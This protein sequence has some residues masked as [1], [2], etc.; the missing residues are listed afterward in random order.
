MTQINTK[1]VEFDNTTNEIGSLLMNAIPRIGED[2]KILG[3][4]ERVG[5]DVAIVR[6]V[7]WA[8]AKGEDKYLVF[9]GCI[10][11][12]QFRAPWDVLRHSKEYKEEP[13]HSEHNPSE[14]H[15]VA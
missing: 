6:K 12:V 1:F 9:A 10:V 11:H 5:V 4:E 13:I 7:E 3:G 8:L 14:E 2:I 15:I